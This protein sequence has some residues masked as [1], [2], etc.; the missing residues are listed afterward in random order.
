MSGH[1][2]IVLANEELLPVPLTCLSAE[3]LYVT[4]L[5]I[6]VEHAQRSLTL[7]LPGPGRFSFWNG[8]SC[9]AVSAGIAYMRLLSSKALMLCIGLVG[10]S[11]TVIVSNVPLDLLDVQDH[12]KIPL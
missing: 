2:S 11:R 4:V 5:A 3:C 1:A 8:R 10:W 9:D 7:Y 12:E 6:V